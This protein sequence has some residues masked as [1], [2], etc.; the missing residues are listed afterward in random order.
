MSR[1][2]VRRTVER[3]THTMEYD[4]DAL[5]ALVTQAVRADLGIIA[6][7]PQPQQIRVEWGSGQL[8]SLTVIVV[9]EREVAS[10]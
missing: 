9:E 2:Y 6:G 8:P 5:E 4:V 10:G 7:R 3:T 1:H